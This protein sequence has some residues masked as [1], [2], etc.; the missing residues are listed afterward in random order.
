MRVPGRDIGWRELV[1]TFARRFAADDI[2]HLAGS[3]AFFGVLSLFPFLLFLFSLASVAIDPALANE[4]IADLA[5]I[6]P[7]AVTAILG[8]RIQALGTSRST[9]VL[10]LSLALSVFTASG[11]VISLT[12]ALNR[13][14]GIEE[15]RPLW[16]AYLVAVAT[17]FAAALLGTLAMALTLVPPLLA[18]LLGAYVGSALL[19]LRFLVAGA[20]MMV[21]WALLYHF[22]PTRKCPFRLVTPGSVAGVLVWVFVSWLFSLYVNRTPRYEVIYGT[23][24]SLII[25]LTWLW[26][27]MIV[28]LGGAELNA[29]LEVPPCP[30]AE[31]RRA[32]AKAKPE[33]EPPSRRPD[34]ARLSPAPRR[35]DPLRLLLAFALG[36]FMG[37]RRAH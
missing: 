12:V 11:G 28:L 4:L 10:G 33:V 37:R 29:I 25:L 5:R 14:L 20:V 18:E 27:T 7:R 3:V 2:V 34:P 23:L 16:K 31:R 6:A 19:G 36:L 13:V 26:I 22:L 24:G 9:G 21:V 32:P 35:P 30:R 15:R 1:A 8:D 17:V